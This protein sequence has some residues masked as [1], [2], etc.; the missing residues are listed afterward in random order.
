MSKYNEES[1]IPHQMS[2]AVIEQTRTINEMWST[3]TQLIDMSVDVNA[4]FFQMAS[5][6][7]CSIYQGIFKD[8][9]IYT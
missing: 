8:K 1:V 6:S 5:R 3:F 7:G 2:F 9:N 4:S